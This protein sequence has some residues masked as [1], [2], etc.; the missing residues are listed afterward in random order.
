MEVLFGGRGTVVTDR[1]K[2]PK[3]ERTLSFESPAKHHN[4]P[5]IRHFGM[6][7]SNCSLGIGKS[8]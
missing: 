1:I 5:L 3:S 6:Y 7:R 2:S 8:G 4:N